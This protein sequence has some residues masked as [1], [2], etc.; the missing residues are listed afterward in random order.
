MS[1]NDTELY[2]YIYIVCYKG[3]I[4]KHLHNLI[5]PHTHGQIK[6]IYLSVSNEE[7]N[8]ADYGSIIAKHFHKFA[9]A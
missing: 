6:L 3:K 8:A 1:S 4:N 2:I 5:T 9:I 7:I